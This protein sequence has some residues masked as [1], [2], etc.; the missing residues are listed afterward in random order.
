ML[1][2]VL[3]R[4]YAGKVDTQKENQIKQLLHN[5]KNKDDYYEGAR[6]LY[7]IMTSESGYTAFFEYISSFIKNHVQSISPRS[8]GSLSDNDSNSNSNSG[9]VS[10]R[11]ATSTFPIVRKRFQQL[12]ISE[13]TFV[14]MFNELMIPSIMERT[15][16]AQKSTSNAPSQIKVINKHYEILKEENN[17]FY[18]KE[19]NDD[20]YYAMTFDEY[21]LLDIFDILDVKGKGT[22]SIETVY[23]FLCSFV[24]REG[25]HLTKFL[26]Q[27]G[28]FVY[29][30]FCK[31]EYENNE[32]ILNNKKII[33][34]KII[35]EPTLPFENID[36]EYYSDKRTS[37]LKLA[38]LL[39]FDDMPIVNHINELQSLI[40]RNR[41]Q[42]QVNAT[43]KREDFMFIYYSV[44]KEFDNPNTR[45]SSTSTS[46]IRRKNKTHKRIVSDLQIIKN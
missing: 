33:E 35:E 18:S 6:T 26:Y 45:S 39:G 19:E 9:R 41:K 2:N 29:D 4:I 20:D 44:F 30:T 15:N 14:S 32:N 27:F 40:L 42:K 10:H 31:D 24:C 23:L 1:K 25:K 11:T 13:F 21:Q 37:F 34:N 43:L 38:M 3:T 5:P 7:Q 36:L 22:V 8:P 12:S 17:N 16:I 46:V 28:N